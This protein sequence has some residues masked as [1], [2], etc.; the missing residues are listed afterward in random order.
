MHQSNHSRF[1]KSHHAIHP[2]NYESQNILEI[3]VRE[4][5]KLV[6]NARPKIG[7]FTNALHSGTKE[8]RVNKQKEVKLK[9]DE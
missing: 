8:P 2:A 6:G 9:E 4:E 7:I 1:N 5:D 3:S